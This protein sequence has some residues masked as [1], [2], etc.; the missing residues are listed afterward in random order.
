MT[1]T[2]S[3]NGLALIAVTAMLSMLAPVGQVAAASTP[4]T[5]PTKRERIKVLTAVLNKMRKDYKKFEG[6][7]PGPEDIFDYKIGALWKRGI[8][9]T[10]T[11][12]AVIEGWND[13]HIKSVIR[14]FDKQYGLPNPQI[15]TI[16]PSG[17]H[18]LPKKCPPGMVK[19]GSYGSCSAWMGELELDVA[20]AHLIAPYAKILISVTPADSEINDDA[21]FQVAPPEMMEA[22]EVISRN[23][24]ANVMSISDGTGESTYGHGREQII[25]QNPGELSA[26]AAGIPVTVGTGDCLAVQ[27]LAVANGQC[28]DT[29]KGRSTAAWDDSPWI[30]AMGGTIPDLNAAGKKVGS[31]PIWHQ[32]VFGEGAGF[33][34]VYRR[35]A[36]QNGVK[37]ITHSA[38]R[39]VPDL[40]M[41]SSDGTSESTPMFAGVLALATQLNHGRNVGP[42]NKV[43]YDVLGPRGAK[44]GIADVVKGNN[45][46]FKGG[47]LAV[48]G[49][50]A[51]KGFDVAS[52]WGTI[53][54]SRFVPSLVAATRAEH[55]DRSI[56][57]QAAAALRRLERSVRLSR[58]VIGAGHTA[59]MTD[60][61]F[62][63][64]HPVV[65]YIDNQKIV[66]LTAGQHGAVA[67]TINPSALGLS[68]GRHTI[69]LKSMLLTATR[70]FRTS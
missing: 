42:V 30:T 40:T 23:H 52:G 53:V 26:A 47:K 69:K 55:Q 24:L 63:P 38:W 25:A 5:G 57:R 67:Y 45:S 49:F 64:G 20:T 65:L 16:Y 35:P 37:S 8:D 34:A 32:G 60:D 39:S 14:G 11:T 19:L 59:R 28:E 54:A 56:R 27:N 48:R 6:F 7:S 62:L 13:P 50:K 10:G 12:I 66:T 2:V 29:T 33:S 41:D 51:A 9:G 18:K 3:R 22:L 46:V 43:L 61:G 68:P 1:R 4:S 44:A 70:D 36:F 17:R 15:R 58:S 31:D 21:A